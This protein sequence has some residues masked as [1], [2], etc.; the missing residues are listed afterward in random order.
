MTGST[1]LIRQY[2]PC[3]YHHESD[4]E[5]GYVTI[6]DWV[7]GDWCGTLSEAQARADS[8]PVGDNQVHVRL[9]HPTNPAVA[10]TLATPAPYA[11]P[12]A[13]RSPG[14]AI[15]AALAVA[16]TRRLGYGDDRVNPRQVVYDLVEADL[17]ARGPIQP[18]QELSDGTHVGSIG[19]AAVVSNPRDPNGE[20]L[21]V[22]TP[23]QGYISFDDLVEA[24]RFAD[25]VLT[26][27]ARVRN[28]YAD[29]RE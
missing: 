11:D 21:H 12:R 2:A 10:Y 20:F 15:E 3:Y 1:R 28:T 18:D 5:T 13:V 22:I 4:P 16:D 27:L 23:G 24:Q 19:S 29:R 8:W 6:S 26:A 17:I 14:N 9:I 25:A 7:T